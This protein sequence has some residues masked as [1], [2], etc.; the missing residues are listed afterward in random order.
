MSSNS[1]TISI[2]MPVYN[3]LPH[4]QDA[5]ESLLNQT[6][7]DFE[8]VLSDN[9]STDGTTRLCE[10]YAANDRRIRYFRQ[11]ENLGALRNFNIVREAATCPYFMWAAA[12]DFWQPRF[13]ERCIKEFE[14]NPDLVSVNVAPTD[15][16]SLAS[17]RDGYVGMVEKNWPE[18]VNALLQ[19]LPDKNARFYGVHKS[20][21]LHNGLLEGFVASD[22]Y[23]IAM[24]A[25]HGQVKVVYDEEAG[26]VKRS[27]G[28]SEKS[29]FLVSNTSRILDKILPLWTFHRKLKAAMGETSPQINNRLAFLHLMFFLLS[30]KQHFLHLARAAMKFLGLKQV[31]A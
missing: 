8:I 25:R 14:R 4:I 13:L 22:W 9:A 2:G 24:M 27:G 6:F 31:S 30:A 26:F 23:V 16:V 19:L 15:T 3:G 10:Q 5:I 1:P 21:F 7:R 12:D 28:A 11:T 29:N 17:I 20:K 18:R